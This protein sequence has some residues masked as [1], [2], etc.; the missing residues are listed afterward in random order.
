LDQW[1]ILA[2]HYQRCTI[3]TS[4]PDEEESVFVYHYF[5]D[6]QQAIDFGRDVAKQYMKSL[7]IAGGY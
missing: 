6:R 3:R 5:R 7:A 1:K 2:R 4:C